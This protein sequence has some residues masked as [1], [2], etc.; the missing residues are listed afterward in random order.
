VF[1]SAEITVIN[2]ALLPQETE[3]QVAT[4]VIDLEYFACRNR[5]I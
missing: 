2:P 3:Q 1:S 5:A 4:P